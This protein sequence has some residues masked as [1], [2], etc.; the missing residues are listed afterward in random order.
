VD[1]RVLLQGIYLLN[2][3]INPVS[4]LSPA[5]GGEFFATSATW[6][7]LISLPMPVEKGVWGKSKWKENQNETR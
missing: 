1:F 4:F 3:G 5:L 2:P 7:A 6:E